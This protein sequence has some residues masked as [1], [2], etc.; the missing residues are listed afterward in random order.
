METSTI[1]ILLGAVA[2][3]GGAYYLYKSGS[4]VGSPTMSAGNPYAPQIM[5]EA[6]LTIPQ[7]ATSGY[8]R[9]YSY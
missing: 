2:L 9:G 8:V 3:G 7:S 1:L 5:R 4:L 6:R